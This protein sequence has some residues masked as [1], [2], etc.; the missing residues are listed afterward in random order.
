VRALYPE[1]CETP[2]ADPGQRTRWNVRDADAT[3]VLVLGGFACSAGTA[4]TIDAARR[5]SRP[6]EIVDLDDAHGLARAQ[7]FID[8]LPAGVTLN[9]A[10][11]RESEVPGIHD[12]ARQMLDRVLGGDTS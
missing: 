8:D 4:V 12:R 7:R 9:I 5:T 11:P 6:I 2:E 3:L 1:L 10:G